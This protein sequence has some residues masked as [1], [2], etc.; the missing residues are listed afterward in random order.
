MNVAADVKQRHEPDLLAHPGVLGTGMSASATGQPFIK[1]YVE[2]ATPSVRA[3]IP[4]SL[5]TVPV[6]VEETGPIVA[7]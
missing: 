5:E 7:Y 1:V 4:S 2:K 3:T 6:Q